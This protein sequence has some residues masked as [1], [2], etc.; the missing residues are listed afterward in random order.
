MGSIA[1]HLQNLLIRAAQLLCFFAVIGLNPCRVIVKAKL[2][3]WCLAAT[4]TACVD[5]AGFFV[6]CLVYG[7]VSVMVGAALLLA[8]NW[9]QSIKSGQLNKE[10]ADHRLLLRQ[11]FNRL[12]HYGRLGLVEG[13]WFTAWIIQPYFFYLHCRYFIQHSIALR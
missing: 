12:D 9:R 1:L 8:V 6:Y 4:N 13:D 3:I 10:L 5:C 11:D 7:A 2:W